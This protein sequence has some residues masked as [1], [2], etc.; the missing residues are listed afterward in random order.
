MKIHPP[1]E[2]RGPFFRLFGT[3]QAAPTSPR[4]AGMC[5]STFSIDGMTCSACVGTVERA[6]RIPG[7][8]SVS[9]ALLAGK[10]V[11]LHDALTDPERIRTAIEDAG[12][13]VV[14]LSSSGPDAPAPPA[15]ARPQSK[16]SSVAEIRKGVSSAAPAAPVPATRVITLAVEGMTCSAC[17]TTVEGALKRVPG[18]VRASVALLA[19]KAE[20]VLSL[21][22]GSSSSSSGDDATEAAAALAEAVEDAGFEAT[23]LS[24]GSGPGGPSLDAALDDVVAAVV[25]GGSSPSLPPSSS[26]P[27]TTAS[28]L[29]KPLQE[30]SAG[31]Q[32][33]QAGASSSSAAWQA[34]ARRVGAGTGVLA[35]GLLPTTPAAAAR[36]SS[37]SASSSSTHRRALFSSG[38]LASSADD[39][40]RVSV[41]FDGGATRL[42]RIVDLFRDEGY[43][44]EPVAVTGGPAGS[45]GGAGGGAGSD[46][47]SDTAL[48][49]AHLA[50]EIRSW[51]FRL[52]VSFFFALPVFILAM[53]APYVDPMFGA[54]WGYAFGVPGLWTRDVVLG[55]LTAPVQFGVGAKFFRHA[56]MGIRGRVLCRRGGRCS[57][58][59]DF[60][61]AAGTFSAYFAS[62]LIMGVAVRD[63]SREEDAAADHAGMAGM[64]AGGGEEESGM[65]MRDRPLHVFFETSALLIA[66]V[67]LGKYLEAVAKGRTSDALSA[68]LDLRPATAVVAVESA[69]E[70][71][72][73]AEQRRREE[74]GGVHPNSVAV[75]LTNPSLGSA[76]AGAEAGAEAGA[77][78]PPP[79]GPPSSSS[80]TSSPPLP[81]APVVLAERLVPLTL[82]TPGDLLKVYPG[83]SI[84]CDG[85]VVAGSSE[86]NESMVTGESMPVHKGPG[87][88]V[89]G[90]TVNTAGL[91][92][93]RASRV[94]GDTVL[95]QIV[96]L[97]EGAQMAKAPIQ[98]FADKISGVFAPIVLA[99]ALVTFAIW[100]G[101][102]ESGALPDGFIPSDSS[103]FLF[104]AFFAI[105][106][107]VIACPCALGL[108]T[109]TAVMVGTGMGAKNGV[110]IKGGDALET[111]HKVNTII[112]D[113]TGTLTEGKPS[114]TDVI[115]L[116]AVPASTSSAATPK[117]TTKAAA[118]SLTPLQIVALVAAAEGGSEHPLG[119]AIVEGAPVSAAAIA[120]AAAAASAAAAMPVSGG[121]AG[122]GLAPSSPSS[123]ALPAFDV[124]TESFSITPG[125]GLECDVVADALG[126][127][128]LTAAAVGG[129]SAAG[130]APAPSSSPPLT[131]RVRVGN[132]AWMARNG[133]VVPAQAEA[134]MDR[135][136]RAGK[137]AVLASVDGRVAAVLGIA[138]RVKAE[139]PGVVAY[140]RDRLRVDVWMVTG[141]NA[142]TA[143]AV[144]KEVGIPSDRVLAEVLPSDKAEAVRRLQAQSGGG[145]G[146]G[147]RRTPGPGVVAMVGDGINDSPALAAADVGMAIGAGAQIAVAAADVVLIRS[148]LRDVVTAIDLSRAVFA[149]IRLNFVW[150]LGYNII[151]I[152][153]AAGILYPATRMTVAPEVAGLAMALS[154]VSVVL[155]SLWLKRYQKPNIEAA[156]VESGSAPP[157]AASRHG[158]GWRAA[159]AGA[160]EDTHALTLHTDGEDG[161]HPRETSSHAAAAA[162][163]SPSVAIL[164]LSHLASPSCSCPCAD[165]GGNK[166]RTVDD[167]D[168]ALAQL[169]R[170]G[171]RVV[172]MGAAG[173]RELQ[174]AAMRAATAKAAASGETRTDRRA[175][176]AAAAAAAADGS[177]GGCIA[178]AASS[179]DDD[180]EAAE[181]K[182]GS[183]CCGCGE[184]PCATAGG[185]EEGACCGGGG[186]KGVE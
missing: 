153:L 86:V 131:F 111:A 172:A 134:Q 32:L 158:A 55:V 119:K 66:F 40:P 81:S 110:L 21:S 186:S 67:M 144:A 47:G 45:G 58:G 125:F 37:A 95:S 135:L 124:P 128:S 152:P 116:P 56:W 154:S 168:S 103:P 85:V 167:W 132:R 185:D 161:D 61:I 176:R 51:S 83:A 14:T 146:G 164:D 46:A 89:V 169:E 147:A 91:L 113:K 108:A 29:L 148:D 94:G 109:P 162:R 178:A 170:R 26:E 92:Y 129:A 34:I 138:D 60:L 175:R 165:C 1:A 180:D 7:V 23:V 87:D 171:T 33:L 13:D 4:S 48:M 101:L 10:G 36:A 64:G 12:Y 166:F 150:A 100:I 163:P 115:F 44:A 140:L 71:A 98:A 31:L 59:M 127:E 11:V 42:R 106:V 53:V 96:R 27:P 143:N 181:D 177:T 82:V 141:D 39:R 50:S 9:V 121:G 114:L 54:S 30:R 5:T 52:A 179:S 156:A 79:T 122:A 123:F 16:S 74:E 78:F 88:E 126:L 93:V 57:L 68:L 160:D 43:D 25:G 136:Q 49:K 112:F 145:S 3:M 63:A 117:P 142:T 69:E 184:C 174:A 84:P 28:F 137:T 99:I 97:V 62:C 80:S 104:S 157:G 20:I 19:G 120:E 139:A 6:A 35:V 76:G 24:T 118:D 15:L 65:A 107:V 105:T 151:G 130:A 18:V 72:W 183:C 8:F 159:A 70:A 182:D 17:V 155:S 2:E 133:L 73:V 173:A 41:T 38:S 102:A 75:E 22:P 149:R 77:T 90:A